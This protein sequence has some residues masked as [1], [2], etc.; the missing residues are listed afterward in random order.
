M[1]TKKTCTNKQQPRTNRLTI[2][3]NDE[4][5][6]AI[7]RYVK[8]YKAKSRTAVIREGALRFVMHRFIDDYPTL[9]EK[10]ELDLLIEKED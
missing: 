7:D 1:R 3:L 2:T 4:E 5:M 8:R 9:F 10:N 6:S